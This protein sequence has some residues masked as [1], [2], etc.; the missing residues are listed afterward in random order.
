MER[1]MA[2]MPTYPP[3]PLGI[4]LTL[5]DQALL[6]A[7]YASGCRATEMLTLRVDAFDRESGSI[8]VNG[9]GDK[10]RAIHLDSATR[11][12]LMKYLDD[13]RH[14]LANP[15]AL[16]TPEDEHVVRGG[17]YVFLTRRG[18][19]LTRGWLLKIVK[20]SD[21]H[22]TVHRIRHSTASHLVVRGAS[23]ED[24]QELLGQDQIEVT[25]GYVQ[26]LSLDKLRAELGKY[27]PHAAVRSE[28]RSNV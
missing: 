7:L 16:Q 9:K 18:T 17:G 2:A 21:K 13:A 23:M 20:R 12:L 11:E 6:S 15:R 5:R 8:L 28:E 10:D 27:G 24:V 25:R 4:A 26:Y 1:M 22:A 19:A 14:L 3:T